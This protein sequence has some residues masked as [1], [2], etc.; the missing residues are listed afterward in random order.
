MTRIASWSAVGD[1]RQAMIS[2]DGQTVAAA[3]EG[4]TIQLWDT[5]GQP[6]RTLCLPGG[7]DAGVLSVHFT[8]DGQTL[9]AAS[10]AGVFRVWRVGDGALLRTHDI[11]TDDIVQLA[12]APDG[13]TL[14]SSADKGRII[15]LFRVEDGTLLRTL[16]WNASGAKN[17]VFLPAA[18][19]C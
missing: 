7:D 15:E 11:P 13:Q 12:F 17:L 9:A 19:C 8:P 3:L 1:L 16:L 6:L 4:G 10:G 14:A 2:P 18:T 5:D